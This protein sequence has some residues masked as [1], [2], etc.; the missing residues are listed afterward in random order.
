M[1]L[2]NQQKK[3][4]KAMQGLSYKRSPLNVK[5]ANDDF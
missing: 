3:M 4:I 2:K 1:S 5:K